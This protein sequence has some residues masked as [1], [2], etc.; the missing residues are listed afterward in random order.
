MI[1]TNKANKIEP[2]NQVKTN[3]ENCGKEAPEYIEWK[4]LKFCSNECVDLK[5]KEVSDERKDLIEHEKHMNECRIRELKYKED[6]IKN[7]I[8]ETRI[9]ESTPGQPTVAVDAFKDGV[10]PKYVI[11]NEIASLKFLDKKAKKKIAGLEEIEKLENED[12]KS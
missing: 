3:C 9:L 1:K 6:Q 5:K 11:E 12:T 7:G 10:K 8:T 2:V 4:K